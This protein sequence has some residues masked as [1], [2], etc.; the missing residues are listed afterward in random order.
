MG[1]DL[2]TPRQ[3]STYG[4]WERISDSGPWIRLHKAQ[5]SRMS[6]D[7]FTEPVRSIKTAIHRLSQLSNLH[8][9]KVF[10]KS[11]MSTEKHAENDKAGSEELEVTPGH[12]DAATNDN[13]IEKPNPE[14]DYS[15]AIKKTDPAEIRLVKKLDYRIMPILWA[16]YFMNYVSPP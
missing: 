13:D 9:G 4:A 16:M 5:V 6:R 1:H 3:A 14:A 12:F 15:G 11:T 10:S 2:G 7:S 8:I